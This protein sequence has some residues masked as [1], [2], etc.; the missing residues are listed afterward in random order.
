M[1]RKK[2]CP[3]EVSEKWAIPYADFLTLLLCLF[4]ALFAMVQAG[5]QAAL[6][7]LKPLPKPL[8]CDLF[9]FRRAYQSRYCPN[10]WYRGAS[11]QRREE[12]SKDKL[13]TGGDVK[14]DGFGG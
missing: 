11:L 4:I 5:K 7:M 10:L 8:V 14:A 2:K 3:E 9:P 6:G 13:G 1:A 12:G